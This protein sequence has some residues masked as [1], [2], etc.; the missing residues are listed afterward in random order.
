MSE[1]TVSSLGLA[2]LL[3]VVLLVMLLGVYRLALA[4][5]GRE[6]PSFALGSVALLALV[7]VVV[8]LAGV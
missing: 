7:V 3:A 6:V 1:L 4:H 5:G 2:A 8:A